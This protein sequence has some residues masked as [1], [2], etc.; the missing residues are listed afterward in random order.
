MFMTAVPKQTANATTST[1][2]LTGNMQ[3]ANGKN[4]MNLARKENETE[5]DYTW[6]MKMGKCYE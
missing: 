2:G 6:K 3:L 5:D 4:E 1:I